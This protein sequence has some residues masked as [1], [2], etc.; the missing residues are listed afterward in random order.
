VPVVAGT[1]EERLAGKVA[2]RVDEPD[3]RHLRG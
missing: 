2:L 1:L 3:L